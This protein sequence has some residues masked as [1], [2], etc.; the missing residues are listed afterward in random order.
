MPY[1]G[2]ILQNYAEQLA[3][4]NAAL[5]TAPKPKP[6]PER[7]EPSDAMSALKAQREQSGDWPSIV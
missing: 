5:D 3:A 4:L 7:E 6:K 2:F 1:L